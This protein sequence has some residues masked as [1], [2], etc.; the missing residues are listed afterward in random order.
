MILL[1]LSLLLAAPAVRID[2]GPSSGVHADVHSGGAADRTATGDV[3]VPAGTE[4]RDVTAMH[5][6]VE[7]EA[8]AMAR[9]VTALGGNV[10]LDRNATVREATA[11]GG[12]VVLDPGA[13]VERDATAV[14]GGVRVAAGASVGRDATGLGGEVAVDSGGRVGHDSV[15]LGPGLRW[16]EPASLGLLGLGAL[17]SPFVLLWSALARF[18][19]FF[20]LALVSHAFWPQRLEALVGELPRRPGASIAL[21]FASVLALPLLGILFVVTLVGIPLALLELLGVAAVGA[22]G[23][24]ALALAVGR[25]L[26]WGNGSPTVQLALGTLLLTL[27]TAIPLLG[28]LAGFCAWLWVFGAALRTRL[29]RHASPPGGLPAS[30][31]PLAA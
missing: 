21:G 24:A 23:F 18:L 14:G 5:G 13:R 10:H 31:P 25:A 20:C 27:L 9:D 16:I 15:S 4:V 19:V 11:V 26:P 22:F 7:L 3:V 1:S 2:V 6:N 28:P 12:S 29:G 8:G 17:L 30:P